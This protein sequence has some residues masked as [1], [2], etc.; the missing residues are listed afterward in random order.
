MSSQEIVE[1]RSWEYSQRYGKRTVFPNASIL[2]PLL[3]QRY[4]KSG[5]GWCNHPFLSHS[6]LLGTF[7]IIFQWL[8]NEPTVLS[9]G[10]FSSTCPRDVTLQSFGRGGGAI[11]SN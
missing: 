10:E 7:F 1:A 5:Q 4:F 2:H 11:Q 8:Q 9:Y 6:C 3:Q